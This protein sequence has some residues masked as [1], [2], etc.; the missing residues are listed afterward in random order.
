MRNR[1][2]LSLAV[3]VLSSVA[4]AKKPVTAMEFAPG[5]FRQRFC[6]D[7][8]TFD[9]TNRAGVSMQAF[10]NFYCPFMEAQE[11]TDPVRAAELFG[12]ILDVID[13]DISWEDN[14]EIPE[15]AAAL[16]AHFTG[17][18]NFIAWAGKVP[19]GASQEGW[20]VRALLVY[21]MDAAHDTVGV[22]ADEDVGVH[23]ICDGVKTQ[24]GFYST[25]ALM[26]WTSSESGQITRY[27]G[28]YHRIDDIIKLFRE[29]R[30][31]VKR[32]EKAGRSCNRIIS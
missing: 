8:E 7:G 28:Y 14:L 6:F 11:T 29:R 30:E 4:H 3:I 2:V 32:Q 19:N 9:T 20:D 31:F 25:R 21:G 22:L 10:A 18:D 5:E 17:V 23:A 27:Q 26:N 1:M 24:V 15:P 16:H 12:R 13:P